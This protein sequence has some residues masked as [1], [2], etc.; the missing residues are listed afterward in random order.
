MYKGH[1]PI[2]DTSVWS[3]GVHNSEYTLVPRPIVAL[4]EYYD[5]KIR[6]LGN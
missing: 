4:Q 2:A 3:R 1:L 5:E 6:E